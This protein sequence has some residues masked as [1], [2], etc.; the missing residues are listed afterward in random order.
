MKKK[1]KCV[2]KCLSTQF[3]VIKTDADTY[4]VRHKSCKLYLINE[5]RLCSM[6]KNGHM[7]YIENDYIDNN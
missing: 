2:K 3:S 4:V 6:I 7:T 1:I 5:R